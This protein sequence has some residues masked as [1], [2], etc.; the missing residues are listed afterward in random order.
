MSDLGLPQPG[1]TSQDPPDAT[2]VFREQTDGRKVAR[3]A[4]GKVVLVDL[5]Q[6]D[7]VRDGEAWFVRLRHRETFAIAEPVE[8]VT[9][10][11]L[12]ASGGPLTNPLAAALR[13][14]RLV[15]APAIVAPAPSVPAEVAVPPPAV[16]AAVPTRPAPTPAATDPPSIDAPPVAAPAPAAALDVSRLVRA[17]D[18][19]AL[20]ID[21]ANT[22]GAARTAGY[23][24][25][26]RK[27]REFFVGSASF[28][29]AFY[30]VADF[31]ASDPLQQ[32]FFDFLSHAGY[33]VRRRPV[34]VI[35][36]PDTG[37]R[38]FK[39]N[40]DTEI[41]LDMLNTVDNYD[42]AFLFSGD[43][44]FERAVELLRSRGKRVFVVSTR[45][46]LSRELAYV[47]DKP[48]V[49]LEHVRGA[50]ARAEPASRTP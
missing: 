42:V 39:G 27:A 12:E 40:L 38:L 32:R 21:G 49:Y 6:V 2:L 13:N 37:E 43:S 22:D 23:F 35:D 50:I 8:R 48:I 3:L 10:A 1:A 16:P 5:N 20:F 4:G 15:A 45:G 18:R 29:A 31:T 36:D 44:D 17:S 41:V 46:P 25:D 47:A 11:A 24:I 7:R 33:I 30:Y 19:V 9:G 14:A 28:Y 34:K 26:F